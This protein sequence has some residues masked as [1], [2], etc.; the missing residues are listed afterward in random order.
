MCT[1]LVKAGDPSSG[2]IH[3]HLW[4][5]G[6]EEVTAVR[7][8]KLSF[9]KER[10]REKKSKQNK[11]LSEFLCLIL[12]FVISYWQEGKRD[13]ITPD[14]IKQWNIN[15]L[16]ALTAPYRIKTYSHLRSPDTPL[17]TVYFIGDESGFVL[18]L[19][20]AEQ[21]QREDIFL[22]FCFPFFS[23]LQYPSS[24]FRSFFFSFLDSLLSLISNPKG[25]HSRII[26]HR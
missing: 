15:N 10:E 12:T 23:V 5:A 20:S 26:I 13:K 18:V 17:L 25:E 22:T 14:E 8:F 7:H 16:E 1:V 19:H 3:L 6:P 24:S 2:L 11:T 21:R 4:Q 9:A